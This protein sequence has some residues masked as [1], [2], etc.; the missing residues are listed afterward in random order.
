M[1]FNSVETSI[2]DS[3][4]RE[5]WQIVTALGTFRYAQAEVDVVFGGNTYTAEPT[6][7]SE[8][9]AASINDP[10]SMVLDF[11]VGNPFVQQHAFGMPPQD[12]QLT[13]TRIQDAAGLVWWVGP[14]TAFNVEGDRARARS[15]SQLADALDTSIPTLYVSRQCNHMLYDARCGID[16]TL[17]ANKK[18][19]TCSTVNGRTITVASVGAVADDYFKGGELVRDTDGDRRTILSQVGTT[20]IVNAPFRAL[21]GGGPG[22]AVTLYRGCKHTLT[23]CVDD[24]SNGVNFGGHPYLPIA[25]PWV[26]DMRGNPWT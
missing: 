20:L 11:P 17:A 16:R 26:G 15:V 12:I 22:D 10:P 13:I 2:Q 25:N 3:A 1:S 21:A 18:T 5:I 6:M 4:P 23:A 8:V 9:V 24:F 14:I 19:T 7:R